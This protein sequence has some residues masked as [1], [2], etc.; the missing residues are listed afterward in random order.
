MSIYGL[1]VFLV[2]YMLAVA[3][4]GPGVAAIVARALGHG[5]R[6]APAFIA[7]FLEIALV[8]SLVLPAVMGTYTLF[9][10][11]ARRHLVRPRTVR[12]VQRGTGAV[13]AGAAVATR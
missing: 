12:W 10:A 1:S 13:M 8:I 4:P 6:G 7:G 9:A 5:L 11:R 3:S 2:A